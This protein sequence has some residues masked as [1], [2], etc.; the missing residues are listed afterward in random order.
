MTKSTISATLRAMELMQVREAAKALQVSENTLR[1]WS[2]NGL[3]QVVRLP[4]GVRR[5]PADEVQRLR[6]LMFENI[7]RAALA[8]HGA[9][10]TAAGPH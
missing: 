3:I 6:G 4:S 9:T 1:R 5:I 7:G 8:A 2:D 10:A